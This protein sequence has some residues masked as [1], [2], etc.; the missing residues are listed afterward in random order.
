VPDLFRYTAAASLTAETLLFFDLETTGLSGGAGTVAFLAAFGRFARTEPEAPYLLRVDQYLLL[1]YPGEG[2]FLAALL[3]ELGGQG[4]GEGSSFPPPLLVTYNGKTFDVPL[5]RTR[6]LMNGIEPPVPFQADLLHPARRL[7]KRLLADCSQGEIETALLG[8]DR[9]GD[10]PGALAPDIWFDFLRTGDTRE[11]RGIS[12]HNVR[13]I[14][15]LARLFAVLTVIAEGPLPARKT[16]PYDIENLALYWR[17]TCRGYS[18]FGGGDSLSRTG[19]AILNEAARE[20]HPRAVLA[21]AR[22]LFREGSFAL[23]RDYLAGWV[24]GGYPPAAKAA[25]L[26]M[27]AVDAE[28]RLRDIPRALAYTEEALTLEGVS[29]KLGDDL[30]RRRER[31]LAGI[32]EGAGGIPA[33]KKQTNGF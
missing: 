31:L 6:C 13:D 24:S 30:L 28:W 11:L 14:A 17:K 32:G 27:L 33:F 26:R 10:T 3:R 23:A 22:D 12:D 7:W 5:L 16:Y 29:Q 15:G 2:D 8:L 9:T 1:E 25:A 20:G 21:L 4:G 19:R 18:L